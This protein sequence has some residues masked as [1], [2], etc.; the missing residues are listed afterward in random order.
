MAVE[1]GRAQQDLG[2]IEAIGI[3]EIQWQRGHR[4]LTLVYQIDEGCRRL[5]WVGQDR[6]VKTLLGFFRWFGKDR[7]AGLRVVRSDMWRPY[8]KVVA[9]KAR[10][11]VHVLDRFHIMAHSG[12]SD[13]LIR[14]IPTAR[15]DASRPVI[16]AD[17]DHLLDG[18]ADVSTGTRDRGRELVCRSSLQFLA[19]GFLAQGGAFELDPVGRVDE[20]VED[21]IGDGGVADQAMPL[22]D[23]D[24]ADAL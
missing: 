21:G 14:S 10:E 15:S 9:K 17:A 12:Y 22:G 18:L 5:L 24:L 11:A 23:G 19:G 8:L 4:Y 1:W 20:P 7:G 13:Q 6:K 16:P 3:D 2:R